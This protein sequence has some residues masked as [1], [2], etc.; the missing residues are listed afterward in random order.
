MK[1]NIEL[2]YK[3]CRYK[4]KGTKNQD[5]PKSA[6]STLTIVLLM[7]LFMEVQ[8]KSLE[9]PFNLATSYPPL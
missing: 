1:G 8:Y 7:Q 4:H 5:I 2:H 9:Y 3:N 6:A